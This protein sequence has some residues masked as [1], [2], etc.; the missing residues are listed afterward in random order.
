MMSSAN[1][2]LIQESISVRFV[3][4]HYLHSWKLESLNQQAQYQLYRA[5]RLAF[6]E[7]QHSLVTVLFGLVSITNR[8]NKLTKFNLFTPRVNNGD[9]V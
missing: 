3:V 8:S 6:F 5:H 1:T 4:K 9:V 2:P 7:G